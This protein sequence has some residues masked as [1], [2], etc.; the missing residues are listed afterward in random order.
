MVPISQETTNIH[1]NHL[2]KSRDTLSA[3]DH[4]DFKYPDNQQFEGFLWDTF[5]ISSGNISLISW[6]LKRFRHR[7]QGTS[8]TMKPHL[9]A[10]LCRI[11]HKWSPPTHTKFNPPWSLS[12]V[13]SSISTFTSK[14]SKGPQRPALDG[15]WWKI[16]TTIASSIA[17]K[18]RAWWG[19]SKHCTISKDEWKHDYYQVWR[20]RRHPWWEI[21]WISWNVLIIRIGKWPMGR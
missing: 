21:G 9:I 6:T 3:W 8:G 19:G 10:E 15:S 5:Q 16:T 2:A 12:V 7:I 4:T 13:T 1:S 20:E 18:G 14:L 17:L 11:L